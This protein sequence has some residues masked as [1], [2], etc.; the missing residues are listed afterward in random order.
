MIDKCFAYQ[1]LQKLLQ[2]KARDLTQ[3]SDKSPFTNK[4]L[5][6]PEW[7]HKNATKNVDYTTIADRLIMVSWSNDSHLTGVVELVYGIPTFP[8]TKKAP[9]MTHLKK[10]LITPLPRLKI[11]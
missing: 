4:K 1:I 5:Q 7:Q 11:S 8:L 10:M 3:C 9:K 6:N 2:E